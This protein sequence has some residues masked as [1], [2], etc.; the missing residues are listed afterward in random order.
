[1]VSPQI[2]L[3]TYQITTNRK[4][5]TLKNI[6]AFAIVSLGLVSAQNMNPSR[7]RLL[8]D[9]SKLYADCYNI[10]CNIYS[11]KNSCRST[12][13]NN[14]AGLMGTSVDREGGQ[15]V[16]R[17][18]HLLLQHQGIAD[19]TCDGASFIVNCKQGPKVPC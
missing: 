7:F 8:V 13:A 12:I 10:R 9:G 19:G 15:F 3:R 14:V 6:V 2:T 11:N 18:S 4:M 5:L 16:Y 1:M 17:K